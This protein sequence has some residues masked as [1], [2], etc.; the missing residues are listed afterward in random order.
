MYQR[1][2]TTYF[3]TTVYPYV[4][5]QDFR[6]DLIARA[7]KTASLRV[8]NHP[9][10]TMDDL[11][12]MKSAGL[13]GYDYKNKIEGFN[14]ASVLL[15]G[16]DHVIL[17]VLPYHKTD[18]ILRRI[19]LDRYDDRDD[20]RTNLIE[21]YDRLLAFINKHLPDN[22]YLEG[23]VRISIRDKIFREVISNILIHRN[24]ANA[25]P[26]KLIIGKDTIHTENSNKP[27]GYGIIDPNNF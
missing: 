22:F 27:H 1:K 10:S 7:R 13:Y 12:L 18:A 14:L 24:Y 5:L 3:E 2:E 9:W 23:D 8:A 17:S 16:K 21:S 4:T 20:I 11:E 19:N 25:Y 26:A 6:Q 15:L